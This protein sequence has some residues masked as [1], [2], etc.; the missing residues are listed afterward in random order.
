MLQKLIK[1]NK[2]INFFLIFFIPIIV[3]LIYLFYN[4]LEVE[5][6][7]VF[8]NRYNLLENPSIFFYYNGHKHIAPQLIAFTSSFFSP[9]QQI[10]FYFLYTILNFIFIIFLLKKIIHEKLLIFFIIYISSFFTLLLYN[11]ANTI[12]L[13]VSI[14]YL[15]YYLIN[16]N[17]IKFNKLYFLIMF[18]SLS[19]SQASI[20]MLP[21]IFYTFIKKNNFKYYHLIL[22]FWTLVL[23]IF[24][25]PNWDSERTNIFQ[26]LYQNFIYF[27]D[28]PLTFFFPKVN[29]LSE[30]FIYSFKFLSLFFLFFV[31]IKKKLP[32]FDYLFILTGYFLI[33]LAVLSKNTQTLFVSQRYFTL[34]FICF[35]IYFNN[36]YFL[37]LNLTYKK[38]INATLLLFFL[39]VPLTISKRFNGKFNNSLNDLLQ[40]QYG[41]KS[42][43]NINR[44][45]HWNIFLLE[46]KF[47]YSDCKKNN[48]DD[49][50]L[51]IIYCD[52]TNGEIKIKVNQF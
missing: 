11:L 34:L 41:M 27:V 23:C 48:S 51:K 15:I 39:L 7:N 6:S 18:I 9:L 31:L 38:I 43:I 12:W 13:S 29:F 45:A 10:F 49:N 33:L 2:N 52:D 1:F 20:V 35:L 3:S 30:V 17:I 44:S 47:K 40:L 4:F 8:F 14:A 28:H 32:L 26:N 21:I 46:K 25:M 5:D 24:V 50:V 36:Y 42:N 22:F 37:N 19:A 16:K